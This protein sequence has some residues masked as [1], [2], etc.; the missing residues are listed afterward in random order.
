MVYKNPAFGSDFTAAL[1]VTVE[2]PDGLVDGNA[3]CT[4]LTIINDG[5]FEKEHSFHVEIMAFAPDTVNIMIDMINTPATVMIQD[6][7]GE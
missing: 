2:L 5:N 3:R 4:T 7:D 1:P 6:D